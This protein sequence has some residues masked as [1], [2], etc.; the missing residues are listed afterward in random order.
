MKPSH[1]GLAFLSTVAACMP[2]LPPPP[3]L[4]V[5]SP[6]RGLVQNGEGQVR[7]TG[8]ALPGS[9]GSPVTKVTVNNKTADVG[10]DGSFSVDVLVPEGAMLLETMAY[11][12]DG[13]RAI[14][15]RAVHVG[16]L[17]QVGGMNE[18]AVR[19]TLSTDAFERSRRPRRAAGAARPDVADPDRA[20][21]R[22]FGN[23]VANADLTV[24]QLALANTTFALTPTDAGLEI[25]VEVSGLSM[26]ARAH[27]DGALVPEG[28]TTVSVTADKITIT[29]TLV[30]TP[31]ADGKLTAKIASPNV[32]TVAMKLQASGLAGSVL[33]LL[34][35]NLAST[36]QKA[37]S[38]VSEKAIQPG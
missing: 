27:Y 8:T 1:L 14:D 21:D 17:R 9:D 33:D 12:E 5:T 13:G 3:D 16:E 24:T 4:L 6:E 7:V 18:D 29:G 20:T 19:L 11:S 28:T 36:V 37:I 15:A 23:S 35:N 38:S 31:T 34:N 25:F 2:S 30:V 32:S 22:S 10:A 26:G